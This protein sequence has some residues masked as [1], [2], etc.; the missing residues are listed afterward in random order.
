MVTF[1]PNRSWCSWRR[2]AAESSR[3]SAL[4]TAV[5]LLAGC[6]GDALKPPPETD[7]GALYWALDLNH[8]AAMLSTDPDY[9]TLTLVAT[10]RDGHG[11]A[12]PMTEVPRY[13]S[14]DAEHLIV[15]SDGRLTATAA[16]PEPIWVQAALTIGNVTRRDSVLVKIVDL[17]DPP[18]L[19][20]FSAEPVAPDSAKTY[21]GFDNLLLR[22]PLRVQATDVNGTSMAEL[23]ADNFL[24]SFRSSDPSIATINNVT[25]EIEGWRPGTVTLYVT[26]T[27]FGVAKADTV[28]YRIGLPVQTSYRIN[29][30]MSAST[31]EPENYFPVREI[32][33]GVGA[34][35]A[36]LWDETYQTIDT[37]DVIVFD[38][39]DV[40]EVKPGATFARP[41]LFYIPME[42]LCMVSDCE[43]GGNI[44]IAEDPSARI[45]TLRVFT[46]PGEYDIQSVK[47]GARG[48][49]VVVDER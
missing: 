3:T 30:R 20:V 49:I 9:N 1:H 32:R 27:A 42:L 25:G 36:F 46:A 7:P 22:V 12:I 43:S 19:D 11:N 16:R 6:S 26:A 33:V 29:S 13:T 23:L 18:V 38:D 37:T 48:R 24:V 34:A 31:G 28:T 14:T 45:G 44:S 21:S 17:T 47:Y 39:A 15:T 10:P 35:V 4:T 5:I 8:H 2:L 40:V 41:D